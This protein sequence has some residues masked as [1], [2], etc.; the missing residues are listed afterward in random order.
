MLVLSRR[1]GETL[2]IG[3]DIAVTVV[4]IEGDRVRLGVA[5]PRSTRILRSEIDANDVAQTMWGNFEIG[6][7][8]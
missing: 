5:A 8:R 2:S 7:R 6:E 3:D 1:Y 4:R